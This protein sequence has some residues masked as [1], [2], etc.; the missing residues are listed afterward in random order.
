MLLFMEPLVRFA[1]KL[2]AHDD[3]GGIIVR[4]SLLKATLHL[5]VTRTDLIVAEPSAIFAR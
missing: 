4:R 5:S 3:A 2:A 1:K